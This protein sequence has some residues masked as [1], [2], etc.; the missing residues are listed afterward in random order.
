[1]KIRYELGDGKKYFVYD[2]EELLLVTYRKPIRQKEEV[3]LF[4]RYWE[5]YSRRNL[6]TVFVRGNFIGEEDVE[7]T[8]VFDRGKLRC[9]AD[10]KDCQKVFGTIGIIPETDFDC[11]LFYTMNGAGADFLVCQKTNGMDSTFLKRLSAYKNIGYG[12]IVACVE[13]KMF[14]LGKRTECIPCSKTAEVLPQ[15]R[16]GN[17]MNRFFCVQ[18]LRK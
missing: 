8:I 18:V 15:E 16:T 12:T 17:N 13:E 5:R 6:C 9:F 4:F 14:V 2:K 7:G 10:G 1:M 3:P 11:P